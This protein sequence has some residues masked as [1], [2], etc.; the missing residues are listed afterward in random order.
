MAQAAGRRVDLF[1][2]T[3]AVLISLACILIFT[4]YREVNIAPV[5]HARDM[6]HTVLTVS[7]DFFSPSMISGMRLDDEGKFALRDR[8]ETARERMMRYQPEATLR[9]Y[10]D[11]PVFS[12]ISAPSDDFLVGTLNAVRAGGSGEADTT[13]KLDGINFVRATAPLMAQTDCSSCAAK[14]YPEYKRGDVIGLREVV[15]PVGDDNARTIRN[16]LYAFA[17]LAAALMCVLGVIFPMIRRHQEESEAITEV[18]EDLQRQATTD[19]LT[20]LHNRR[21]FEEAL[22]NC[23]DDF[24]Q[25]DISLGLLVFDIDRFKMVNDTYGHDAG[26]TVLQEVALRL[27]AITR[28]SDVVARIGGEEFAVITP[29][30]TREQLIMVAE[31]YR[32]SIGSLKID[33]GNVILRPSISVGIAMNDDRNIDAGGMFK[34]ADAKLYE[35]K[36]AGRNRVAA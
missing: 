33:L 31:R 29:C 19:P 30:V 11:H 34:L 20:R 18:A 32:E 15:M 27:K 22:T 13:S 28:G 2:I 16:L 35:A 1:I 4:A 25:R 17:V 3:D 7:D 21:Y 36:R 26:D 12:D 23:L 24:R 14:G 8:L 9:V 5:R 10:S 6:A